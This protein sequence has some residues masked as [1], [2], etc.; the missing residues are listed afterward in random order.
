MY[1]FPSINYLPHNKWSILNSKTKQLRHFFC[2]VLDLNWPILGW[3]VLEK[4]HNYRNE[5]EEEKWSIFEILIHMP[6]TKNKTKT[7]EG[8][9]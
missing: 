5:N 6:K 1:Q 8:E 4:D 9:N 2:I 3:Y 7:E